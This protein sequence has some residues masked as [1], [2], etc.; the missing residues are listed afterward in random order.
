MNRSIFYWQLTAVLLVGAAYAL[1]NVVGEIPPITSL[2]M[3]L[4]C[5]IFALAIHQIIMWRLGPLSEETSPYA[6]VDLDDVGG[7]ARMQVFFD[8]YRVKGSMN[9]RDGHVYPVVPA[10]KLDD[11]TRVVR[12]AVQ[13]ALGWRLAGTDLYVRTAGPDDSR[14]IGLTIHQLEQVLGVMERCVEERYSSRRLYRGFSRDEVMAMARVATADFLA[15]QP[16]DNAD[17]LIIANAVRRGEC[18]DNEF[19]KLAARTVE[20]IVQVKGNDV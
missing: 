2:I 16:N 1:F 9:V 3:A 19:V 14:I 13:T 11:L 15:K 17:N 6:E 7:R 12:M 8:R 10:D 4:A 20:L 18:D 5:W